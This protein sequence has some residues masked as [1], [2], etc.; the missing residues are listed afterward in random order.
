MFSV[1]QITY[2]W[3]SPL[4]LILEKRDIIKAIE[5]LLQARPSPTHQHTYLTD[6]PLSFTFKFFQTNSLN[7]Q[8]FN[9]TKK[10]ETPSF[11]NCPKQHPIRKSHRLVTSP[12][13]HIFGWSKVWNS[14]RKALSQQ[15]L[16]LKWKV[17]Y[18]IIYQEGRTCYNYLDFQLY[19]SR[20]T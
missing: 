7:E 15:E 13:H 18:K 5:M 17:C 9:L 8:V 2:H 14:T 20:Y 3:S 12:S 4:A 6:D 19:H 11:F 10:S 16:W 1:N